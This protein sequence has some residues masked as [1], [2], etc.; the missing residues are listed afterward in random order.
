MTINKKKTTV[1]V[2]MREDAHLNWMGGTSWDVKNPLVRLRMAASSCFFGEPQYYHESEDGKRGARISHHASYISSTDLDR[3]RDT[4]GALDPRDWRGLT[5][6][7]LMEKTIDEA[8]DADPEAT[9]KEAVRLRQEEHMRSTP[10][11]ILVRAA[12]HPKVRGTGLVT[13]YASQIVDRADE[14][15]V[16]LA[17]HLAAYGKD[18]PLPNSLK[19]A[20]KS[21]LESSKEYELAKYRMEN[22]VVKTVD[23]VNLVHA[24]SEAVSKLVKGQLT[25]TGATWE[26]IIS[27]E[28]STKESWSKAL[29]VM[30]HMA[31]LRNMRNLLQKGVDPKLFLSKLVAGAEKGKQLP[32]R[33][34]SAYNAIKEIGTSGN[35]QDAI[36][37]C[38]K[39]SLGNLPHFPGRVM[40]LADN[41][42]SARGTATSSMGTMRMSTI[43]NLTA[44]LT[45]MVS[46]D[47]YVGVFGDALEV[48]PVRKGSSVFDQLAKVET[49]GDG[50]GQSTENGIWLFWD[51]A[52][53]QKEHWDHVFV[54]SDMQ[55]GHGGLYGT[56][57]RA[58]AEYAWSDKRHIDVAKLIKTYRQKVNPNVHVYLVQIAGYQDALVPEFYDKTYILGGWGD[59]ILRFAA[60]MSGLKA[61]A[62]EQ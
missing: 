41:S 20:W 29:D 31:M 33:Y 36:E 56:D 60:E 34:V 53:K 44:I 13:K 49:L 38:L 48:V 21:S 8:L 25:N 54:Y 43:G 19:K 9:L 5:P 47:G 35:V 2:K 11:V 39:L 62:V 51:K 26:S 15:A 28:G 50:V 24:K 10:Q 61:P 30:G 57:A 7:K 6:Q 40:S 14:P 23:V 59:G 46:E 52:I 4:L 45:G 1:D 42:G 32:F 18:A 27:A 12:H 58:Y 16:G 37:Q 55:A 17:Y 3:L 22:R